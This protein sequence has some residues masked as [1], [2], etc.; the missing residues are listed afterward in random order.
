MKTI[1]L[2]QK[3][4]FL[5]NLILVNANNPINDQ[6]YSIV[7]DLMPLHS[8][9]ENISLTTQAS[10]Q[11]LKL[12]HACNGVNKIIPISGYRSLYEQIKILND[13]LSENG[14]EFTNKYV[15]KP[16]CSEHQTGLAIDVAKNSNNI[17]FICPN[18][19]YTGF[20]QQFRVE[21]AEYGFIERYPSNKEHITGIAAEPW[22][23][24]YVGFP[25]S[26]IMYE[27]GFTLEEYLD[28]IMQYNV[29]NPFVYTNKQNKIEI[30]FIKIY[31][32][33]MFLNVLDKPFQ[34]SGTNT[35]GIIYTQWT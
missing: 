6:Y 33:A 14:A 18:F 9:I 27:N 20:C 10:Q 4:I 19:P 11:L 35:D 34:I 5:G 32:S 28:F 8:I 25:H 12:L 26:K 23:F 2:T 22:H 15:A 30:S 24:R 7:H 13:C 31:D 21:A 29:R 16:N 17:D 3:N 1:Q